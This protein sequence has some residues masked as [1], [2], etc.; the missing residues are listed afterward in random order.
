[1]SPDVHINAFERCQ[2][3]NS[4]DAWQLSDQHDIFKNYV[5]LENCNMDPIMI[6]LNDFYK[7]KMCKFVPTRVNLKLFHLNDES[8]QEKRSKLLSIIDTKKYGIQTV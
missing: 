4:N 3:L 2:E 8:D 5:K 1:M 6:N 7:T